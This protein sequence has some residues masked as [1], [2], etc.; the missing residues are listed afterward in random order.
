MR[1]EWTP[2]SEPPEDARS[3]IVWTTAGNWFE[4]FYRQVQWYAAGR[5]CNVSAKCWRDV[6][7]PTDQP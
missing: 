4:G 2:A 6:E 5:I 3:V 1:Y 7:P